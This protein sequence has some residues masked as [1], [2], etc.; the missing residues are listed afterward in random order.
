[1]PP[2]ESASRAGGMPKA[3]RDRSLGTLGKEV[4]RLYHI[5]AIAVSPIMNDWIIAIVMLCHASFV[6][7]MAYDAKKKKEIAKLISEKAN[8][9]KTL[10][11]D[12]SPYISL[13]LSVVVISSFPWPLSR[14]SFA[15]VLVSA[16]LSIAVIQLE[17]QRKK[18]KETVNTLIKMQ[19]IMLS[20]NKSHILLHRQTKSYLAVMRLLHQ[21]N[22]LSNEES[23]LLLKSI[24]EAFDE[25][26][27]E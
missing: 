1:M 18:Q 5:T 19:A 26:E 17:F 3:S 8:S 4:M 11:F 21:K 2:A 15:L 13:V 22:I 16:C 27:K 14:L 10:F 24:E 25:F 20:M 6:A 23:D 12:A 9:A 7:W